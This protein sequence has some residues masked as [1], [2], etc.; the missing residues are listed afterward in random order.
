MQSKLPGITLLDEKK[1]FCSTT[2]KIYRRMNQFLRFVNNN[3][4][5]YKYQDGENEMKN[6]QCPVI[7]S[8]ITYG[9]ESVHVLYHLFISVL[10]LEIRVRVGDQ[11]E[12]WKSG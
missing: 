8:T 11:G 9:N 1:I 3:Q 6:F 7:Y 10:A 2:F 12:G 5:K 4:K